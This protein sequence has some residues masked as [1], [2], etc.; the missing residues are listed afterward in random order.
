M[1]KFLGTLVLCSSIVACAGWQSLVASVN[2]GSRD[3]GFFF[4]TGSRL[5]NGSKNLLIN[6]TLGLAGGPV[7]TGNDVQFSGGLL[8][9]DGIVST[10]DGAYQI[11]EGGA[12]LLTGNASLHAQPG[13]LF[14]GVAV[15]GSGNVIDGSLDLAGPIVLANKN[16]SVSMAVQGPITQDIE[17]NKGTL[18]LNADLYLDKDV[19]IVGPGTIDLQYHRLYAH[20]LSDTSWSANITFLHGSGVETQGSLTTPAALT[21]GQQADGQI[22]KF[23]D[24]FS[25][26]TNDRPVNITGNNVVIDG[27]GGTL[28]FVG[29][30]GKPQGLSSQAGPLFSVAANKVVT[31]KNITLTNITQDT[32]SLGKGSTLQLGEN[33]TF[34]LG[35]DV[36]LTS[37][38]LKLIASSAVGNVAQVCGINGQRKLVLVPSDSN[39]TT[40][41]DLNNNSLALRD[42]EFA[43]IGFAA[44]NGSSA[45][46]AL[47]GGATVDI[48]SSTS[49]NF[50]VE[51]QNNELA[52]TVDGLTLSGAFGFDGLAAEN[53]L[54]VRFILNQAIADK[55]VAMVDGAGVVSH[56]PVK[57]GNYLVIFNGDT[58][59]FLSNQSTL[60]GLI[61][62][63][64]S[65]SICNGLNTNTNGFVIDQNSFLMGLDLEIIGHP[66]KQN[67]ARFVLEARSVSGLGIDQAFIRATQRARE[68]SSPR[69][70]TSFAK[71]RAHR[72]SN[73]PATT[74]KPVVKKQVTQQQVQAVL[75]NNKKQSKLPLRSMD[76][77]E[78]LES[79]GFDHVRSFD[80]PASYERVIT[81]PNYVCAGDESGTALYKS[82]QVSNFSTVP[83]KP[84]NVTLEDGSIVNQKP[85]STLLIDSS[86]IVNVVGR[87]NEIVVGEN[88]VI[89]LSSLGFDNAS[90]KKS[91]L[92]I[93]CRQVGN[94]LPHITL[95]GVLDLPAGARLQFIGGGSVTLA[96]KSVISLN[97]SSSNQAAFLISAGINL[98]LAPN[99]QAYVG[100]VG[101]F[102][103]ADGGVI[104]VA[105]GAKLNIADLPAAMAPGRT[106]KVEFSILRRALLAIADEAG[107]GSGLVRFGAAGDNDEVS[108]LMR[109]GHVAIGSA[110]SM[111][112]NV[113]AAGGVQRGLLKLFAMD[114]A[115]I[116]L[117]GS[118]VFGPNRWDAHYKDDSTHFVL[119]ESTITGE[120]SIN[121]FTQVITQNPLTTRTSTQTAAATNRTTMAIKNFVAVN[122]NALPV[123][124]LTLPE[125]LSTP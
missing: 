72:R 70:L 63:D 6:G 39:Q 79:L 28:G 46:I 88:A 29:A 78:E 83:T 33:V 23:T 49:L 21:G 122:T 45:S 24:P 102:E 86:H 32:F 19:S 85:G 4:L 10:L 116:T 43:G 34:E 2:F 68:A 62:K 22:I 117:R 82:S 56:I 52:L 17:L 36:Y 41:L 120:G 47:T 93:R 8:E 92:L 60:A 119:T 44:P 5:H 30:I 76:I 27:E 104:R 90:S 20:G 111:A 71:E 59:V 95:T 51:G 25:I 65:V 105:G 61:F 13:S 1:R 87:G 112:F 3:A 94:E 107:T 99:A 15:S 108:V 14:T 110:G 58:G 77:L 73:Q 80:A 16:A 118:L 67:S 91:S 18:L 40:M 89:D 9:Q 50:D 106:N 124:F 100:G 26:V 103:V 84:C 74:I 35:S 57:K 121:A 81:S 12:F 55:T 109:R 75:A 64:Q 38:S 115:D 53:T 96:D 113:D 123:E 97:G 11:S 114:H 69:V 31:L 42:V 54:A 66:I 101:R 37:G 125:K 98:T 48:G 7:L